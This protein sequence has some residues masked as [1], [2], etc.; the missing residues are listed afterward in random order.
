M[1]MGTEGKWKGDKD[2]L[3]ICT[4][5]HGM[6]GNSNN[7]SGQRGRK[8][9]IDFRLEPTKFVM[10]GREQHAHPFWMKLKKDQG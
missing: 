3:K 2:C 1:N 9:G 6:G 10:P 4:L 7:I 5:G 8:G